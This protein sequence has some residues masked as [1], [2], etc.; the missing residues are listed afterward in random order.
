MECSSGDFLACACNNRVLT[1]DPLP[2]VRGFTSGSHISGGSP[3]DFRSNTVTL[4]VSALA[5]VMAFTHGLWHA[6]VN[7]FYT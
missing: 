4:S 2:K 6:T 3:W 1:S 7:I 5:F